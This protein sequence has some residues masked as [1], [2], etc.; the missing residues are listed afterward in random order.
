M[1]EGD[2]SQLSYPTFNAIPLTLNEESWGQTGRYIIIHTGG[3][4]HW[5]STLLYQ[6]THGC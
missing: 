6:V 4:L 1:S 2:F 3:K 5:H